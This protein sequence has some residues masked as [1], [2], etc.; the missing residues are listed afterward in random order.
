MNIWCAI[1][2]NGVAIVANSS[3]VLYIDLVCNHNSDY[4]I[5]FIPHVGTVH[6]F[7]VQ[8]QLKG[9]GVLKKAI[10]NFCNRF[11]S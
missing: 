9:V 1:T 6:R 11:S 7:G 5:N 3:L 10:T 2:T 8:S 4:T